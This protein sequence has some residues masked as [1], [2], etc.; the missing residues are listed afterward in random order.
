MPA[1]LHH[2]PSDKVWALR[3]KRDDCSIRFCKTHPVIEPVLIEYLTLAMISFGQIF[4][5][6]RCLM[7]LF[8]RKFAAQP[9]P[10]DVMTWKQ[11][12]AVVR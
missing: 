2:W 12:R 4:Q 9:F 7:A 6:I 11:V 1:N 3:L 8:A 10:N 5:D